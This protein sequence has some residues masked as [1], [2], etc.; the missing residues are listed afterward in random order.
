MV[1]QPSAVDGW[2][3]RTITDFGLCHQYRTGVST[4]VRQTNLVQQLRAHDGHIVFEPIYAG[5]RNMHVQQTQ[6]QQRDHYACMYDG[7]PQ[8]AKLERTN[9]RTVLCVVL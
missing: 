5:A 3:H 7:A 9:F 6:T 4:Q 2:I 8:A 1:E